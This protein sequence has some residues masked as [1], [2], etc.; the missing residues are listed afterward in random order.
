MATVRRSAPSRA[1]AA[2][3]RSSG[4][5]GAEGM[6]RMREE[7]KRQEAQREARA[8]NAD[9]PFRF[10]CPV[11]ETREIIIVDEKPDFFR[12]EHNLKDR[13]SGKWNVFTACINESENCPVCKNAEREAYF[14]MYLTVI[15]LTPYTNKDNE[16]VPWSKKLLVVKPAQQKKLT[17]MYERLGSLRGVLLSM[18]RDS[19]KDANIGN[20]I[21]HVETLSEDDLLAYESE[22]TDKK[23][24]VHVVLGHEVFDY[25]A[26]FPLP[27]A[28]QLRA[29]VGGQPEPGSREDNDREDSRPARRAPAARGSSSG[30]GWD[31]QQS[32]RAPARAPAR[33]REIDP[34]DDPSVG[35]E[36]DDTPPPRRAAPRAAAAPARAPARTAPRRA[37]PEPEGYDDEA[38][39]GEGEPEVERRPPPRRAAAPERDAPQR[40]APIGRSA[41]RAAEPEDDE[42]APRRASMAEQRRALR[43]G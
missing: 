4:Y 22:Y 12:Y 21:E 1:A 13:R 14:A 34:E 39:D 40:R 38:G 36:A 20:D 5:R 31:Q 8:M 30:D 26:L 7:E 16:E 2:P 23:D 43:R 11:G 24:K 19:D 27:T 37:A 35:A 3:A 15:D 10:F 33:G 29:V 28:Q 17:R 32:R 25:D 9:M 41:P 42:P 6:A 18:T